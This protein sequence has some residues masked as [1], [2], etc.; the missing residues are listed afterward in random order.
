MAISLALLG[1]GG[2]SL[3]AHL[4]PACS[5]GRRL[6]SVLARLA[7]VYRVLLILTPLALVR[8]DYDMSGGVDLAFSANLVLAC[9][10]AAAPSF[11]AGALVAAAIRGYSDRVGRAY[12]ASSPG[13]V[14]CRGSAASMATAASTTTTG[15]AGAR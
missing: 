2:G 11:A 9:V 14:R 4:P 10:L 5:T 15:S 3:V 1:T 13:A 6:A 7:L 8:L 12:A